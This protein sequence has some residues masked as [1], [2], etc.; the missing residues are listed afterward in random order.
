MMFFGIYDSVSVKLRRLNPALAP[1]SSTKAML[2]VGCAQGTSFALMHLT[3]SFLTENLQCFKY[4]HG[5]AIAPNCD[6]VPFITMSG[7]HTMLMS[8]CHISWS[9]IITTGLISNARWTFW[10]VFGTHMATA[11]G[12]LFNESYGDCCMCSA[13]I[14][15][16][17]TVLVVTISARSLKQIIS[18]RAMYTATPDEATARRVP[19]EA[20]EHS[21]RSNLREVTEGSDADEHSAGVAPNKVANHD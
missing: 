3:T 17:I 1:P 12:T 11:V 6:A 20:P 16:M 2:A 13:I 14:M 9:M 5:D 21:R 7:Y 4:S 18:N 19:G 15:T 8:L 10:F